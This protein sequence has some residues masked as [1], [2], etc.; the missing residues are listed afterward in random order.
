[1]VHI[2]NVGADGELKFFPREMQVRI[3]D[4]IV[5]IWI[6]ACGQ[7]AG[8][9]DGQRGVE[10]GGHGLFCEGLDVVD[11]A[12]SGPGRVAEIGPSQWGSSDAS[13]RAAELQNHRIVSEQ[14]EW[15][16]A[17]FLPFVASILGC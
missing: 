11:R 7:R 13:G 14:E 4:T 17:F 6:L 10:L 5:G 12:G 2:V 1:M 8:R 16:W 3:K 15:P 9:T